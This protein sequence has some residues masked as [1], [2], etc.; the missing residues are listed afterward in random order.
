M[1]YDTILSGIDTDTDTNTNA[2]ANTDTNTNTSTKA[3]LYYTQCSMG[4]SIGQDRGM[5]HSMQHIV[6]CT[7]TVVCSV[8]YVAY[9]VWYVAELM[10]CTLCSRLQYKVRGRLW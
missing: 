2:N 3:I 8:Q 7:V 9:G 4:G 1:I 10:Q 6:Q 5:A